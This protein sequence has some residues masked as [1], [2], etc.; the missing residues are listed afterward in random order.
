MTPLIPLVVVNEQ[1][2]LSGLEA[3]KAFWEPEA[4]AGY[5]AGE[6]HAAAPAGDRPL[7][8]TLPVIL[9]A[10]FLDG[11]NPCALAMLMFLLSYVM[12]AGVQGEDYRRILTVGWIYAGATFL[13]YFVIGA[14]L[15]TFLL[16]LAFL[17]LALR[18]VYGL[19]VL[20]C[21]AFAGLN[22]LD[23]HHLKSGNEKAVKTQLPK[24][25]KHVIH[26]LVRNRVSP[27]S[28]YLTTFFVSVL[29]SLIDFLCTGQIYLPTLTFLL[30]T[31][32]DRWQLYGLLALYNLMF[33]VPIVLVFYAVYGAKTLL[34]V[35]DTLTRHLKHIKLAGALFYTGMAGYVGMMLWRLL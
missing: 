20:F 33:I 1:V 24:K 4:L 15:M 3:I 29:I 34:T 16:Q 9:A 27:T 28:L 7:A 8:F 5:L 21:L 6:A 23:Y 32:P 35:S 11:L 12:M 19:T 26:R 25:L 31:R 14:G 2:A 18:L 17:P 22:L 13:T 10:G 30:S